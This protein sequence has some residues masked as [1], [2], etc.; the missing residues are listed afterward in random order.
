MGTETEPP[1]PSAIVHVDDTSNDPMA[2]G[3]VKHNEALGGI[4][5]EYICE[6]G[7]KTVW[8]WTNDR[9][10]VTDANEADAI[11]IDAYERKIYGQR[12]THSGNL[13]N[14]WSLD[15]PMAVYENRE[16]YAVHDA[17]MSE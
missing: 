4:C 8:V 9:V 1:I 5:V 17:I 16:A 10:I 2:V 12:I 11:T 14:R 3:I 13:R 7:Q 6:S 15:Y